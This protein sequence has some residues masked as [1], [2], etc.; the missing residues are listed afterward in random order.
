MFWRR[1]RVPVK[2]AIGVDAIKPEHVDITVTVPELYE[3]RA[4]RTRRRW[5]WPFTRVEHKV[6]GQELTVA[7]NVLFPDGT[8]AHAI[9]TLK[10]KT[11]SP[12]SR[13]LRIW[14]YTR[15]HAERLN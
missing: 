10:G 13:I 8:V 14:R 6:C 11:A 4:L 12:Y 1:N 3:V 5:W 9:D 2:K 7:V 15:G